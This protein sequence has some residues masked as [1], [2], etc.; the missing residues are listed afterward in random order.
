MVS[1]LVTFQLLPDSFNHDTC[2][3]LATQ[4]GQLSDQPA[5]FFVLDAE[6]RHKIHL[7]TM[8]FHHSTMMDGE[9]I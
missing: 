4:F 7:S 5:G 8:L 6:R 9:F 3:A 1:R 2:H